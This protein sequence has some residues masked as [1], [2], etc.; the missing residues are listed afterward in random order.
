MRKTPCKTIR[1]NNPPESQVWGILRICVPGMPGQRPL[2]ATVRYWGEHPIA[3]VW[4]HGL[5][6]YR[7]KTQQKEELLFGSLIKAVVAKFMPE[8][9]YNKSV[10]LTIA[11]SICGLFLATT[12]TPS[13]FAD[14][15]TFVFTASPG[16]PTYFN[17]T[18]IEIAGTAQ[19]FE[20]QA[21]VYNWN[22]LDTAL[23][24]G[25]TS[26]LQIHQY[27]CSFRQ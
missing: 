13:A 24:A 5:Y 21:D 27:L 26:S 3:T 11:S 10:K 8:L 17:G 20:S 9:P 7:M 12:A 6:I 19:S 23:P 16:Q 4:L 18:T 2:L 25:V 1:K 22:L 15:Y 14:D